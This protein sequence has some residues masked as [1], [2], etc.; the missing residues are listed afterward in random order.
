MIKTV[1]SLTFVSFL[2]MVKPAFSMSKMEFVDKL[3]KATKLE[4]YKALNAINAF[5]GTTTNIIAVDKY[6]MYHH[7]GI[8]KVLDES[9]TNDK[10]IIFKPN[11]LMSNSIFKVLLKNYIKSTSL[12]LIEELKTI[13]FT[14]PEGNAATTLNVLLNKSLKESYQNSDII[15]KKWPF[16]RQYS[17]LLFQRSLCALEKFGKLYSLNGDQQRLI[18]ELMESA[19]KNL[20]N[21]I[22]TMAKRN[23]INRNHERRLRNAISLSVKQENVTYILLNLFKLI[24]ETIKQN[25]VV[26]FQELGSFKIHKDMAK[27]IGSPY[28]GRE[29][30]LI[31]KSVINFKPS[32]LLTERLTN[33][34]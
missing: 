17:Q 34:Y 14:D 4:K 2:L 33:L 31:E 23:S 26:H 32:K 15:L 25:K 11:R 12:R 16:R 24:S 3:A 28:F 30:V 1:L 8:F 5:I 6:A 7:L 27:L 18:N 29:I 21:R 13:Q 20:M 9:K 22:E 10:K 19:V